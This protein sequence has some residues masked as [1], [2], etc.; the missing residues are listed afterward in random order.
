MRTTL[1]Q[2][3]VYGL[4]GLTLYM[5]AWRDRV[6]ARIEARRP[7][8]ALFAVKEMAL[9]GDS[10]DEITWE[11]VHDYWKDGATYR[12]NCERVQAIIRNDIEQ[13]LHSRA[14]RE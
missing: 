5:A 12:A 2:L 3:L 6:Q 13:R 1:E 8:P 11:T 10:A 14:Q 4:T 9:P 7:V